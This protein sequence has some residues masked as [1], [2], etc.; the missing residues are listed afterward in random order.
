MNAILS[1]PLF[2]SM[3]CEHARKSLN[4][5]KHKCDFCSFTGTD[6]DNFNE[7]LR[8][9]SRCQ[10]YIESMRICGMDVDDITKRFGLLGSIRAMENC[11]GSCAPTS[12][13]LSSFKTFF[14]KMKTIPEIR[15]AISE[16]IENEKRKRENGASD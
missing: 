9:C 2:A 7:D 12:A 14:N 3:V 10:E 11:I 4:K 5:Q 15:Q 1:H 6:L 16:G 8:T 13:I